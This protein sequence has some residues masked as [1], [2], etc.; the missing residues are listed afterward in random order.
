[1]GHAHQGDHPHPEDGAR[2]AQHDGHGNAGNVAGTYPSGD[3][4]HQRLERA[5]LATLALKG[6]GEDMKHAAEVAE[7]YEARGEGEIQTKA[8]QHDDQQLAP[9]QVVEN[10]EHGG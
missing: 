6:F 9:D 5:E 7:L 2:A 8:D 10:V 1:G 3:R 4:E